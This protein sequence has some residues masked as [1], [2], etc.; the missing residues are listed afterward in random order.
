MC[1]NTRGA[2]ESFNVHMR[3]DRCIEGQ[4]RSGGR[5]HKHAFAQPS[6]IDVNYTI[7]S[8][9]YHITS[10]IDEL[11]DETIAIST[12]QFNVDFLRQWCHRQDILIVY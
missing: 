5:C 9:L 10:I 6:T 4:K 2:I 12:L 8:Y 7:P 11:L 3:G 1:G